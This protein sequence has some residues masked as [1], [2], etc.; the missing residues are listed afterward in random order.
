MDFNTIDLILSNKALLKL[1][2]TNN[3]HRKNDRILTQ[4]TC[5][6][7]AQTYFFFLSYLTRLHKRTLKNVGISSVFITKL[8][9]I[10]LNLQ[11]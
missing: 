10:K 7:C 8:N 5:T 3:I 11:A 4:E 1:L 2:F 9:S 6:K